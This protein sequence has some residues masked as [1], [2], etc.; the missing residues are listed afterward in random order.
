MEAKGLK[1]K[2]TYKE[3]DKHV[4]HL[5]V[6]ADPSNCFQEPEQELLGLCI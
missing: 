5:N 4:Q 6:S 2:G 1:V 3:V